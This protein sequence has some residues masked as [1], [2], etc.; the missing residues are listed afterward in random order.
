MK[1]GKG[2]P[3]SRVLGDLI[4]EI[5]V[6]SKPR[7]SNHEICERMG[8]AESYIDR[9]LGKEKSGEQVPASVIKRLKLMYE[10]EL[11]GKVSVKDSVE[12]LIGRQQEEI[13]EL[14]VTCQML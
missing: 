1:N 2:V 3:R 8:H 5:K 10:F 14:R 6:K 7:P 12:R 13:I 9:L 11:T 4:E